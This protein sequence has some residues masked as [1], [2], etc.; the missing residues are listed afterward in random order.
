MHTPQNLEIEYHIYPSEFQK[1]TKL[2]NWLI[3]Y[4]KKKTHFK[5][6]KYQ[7]Y[8]SLKKRS[9]F[10]IASDQVLLTGNPI[11]DNDSIEFVSAF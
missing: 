9:V 1:V 2:S 3:F 11:S 10:S 4:K 6:I 7:I 8:L 5:F